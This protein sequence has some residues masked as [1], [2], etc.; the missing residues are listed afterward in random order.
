MNTL[1]QNSIIG[2]AII[3]E[4]TLYQLASVLPSIYIVPYVAA[5][6]H[7]TYVAKCDCAFLYH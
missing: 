4:K 2:I 1:C 6:V 7:S 5:R 3:I